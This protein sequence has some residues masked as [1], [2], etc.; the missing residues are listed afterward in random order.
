MNSSGILTQRAT[1][2]WLGPSTLLLSCAVPS[3]EAIV[4]VALVAG[5]RQVPCR[6][7][8]LGSGR[9]LVV[10]EDPPA[11]EQTRIAIDIAGTTHI[12]SAFVA[13]ADFGVP[14]VLRS[15]ASACEN[16]RI[17]ALDFI[18]SQIPLDHG[19]GGSAIM[20]WLVA[21]L[22]EPLPISVGAEDEGAS[23]AL[24]YVGKTSAAEAYVRGWFRSD[25]PP[26]AVRVLCGN[27]SRIELPAAAVWRD[28]PEVDGFFT[29][30][31]KAREFLFLC[32]APSEAEADWLVE[33]TDETGRSVESLPAPVELDPLHVRDRIL[34][35]LAHFK[36]AGADSVLRP[37]LAAVQR[38]I[39]DPGA[40]EAVYR[41]GSQPAATAASVIVPLGDRADL[42]EN[43]LL[44]FCDAPEL[45]TTELLFVLPRSAAGELLETCAG[46]SDLYSAA[47]SV[48]AVDG[49]R[50]FV[51]L[52]NAAVEIAG[53]QILVFLR[54]V[55]MPGGDGWL[56]RAA[57]AGRAG[58]G[59]SAWRV[60]EAETQLAAVAMST[61]HFR[62]AGGLTGD[63][64]DRADLEL[65]SLQMRVARLGVPVR[66]ID[67][68]YDG[69]VLVT[70]AADPPLAGAAEAL[71]ATILRKLVD[72]RVGVE[73]VQICAKSDGVSL[74]SLEAPGA[75]DESSRIRAHDR[76][77]YPARGRHRRIGRGNARR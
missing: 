10:A 25:A 3:N 12:S 29:T 28:R 16:A 5:E 6:W 48:V 56:S 34:N 36:G 52:A 70:S 9:V 59:I 51:S 24:E 21:A 31:G 73:E 47:F 55:L 41:F 76:G 60:D 8:T 7:G 23:V 62:R 49:N 27:G 54:P 26:T 14:S 19:D 33:A 40:V 1:A 39:N 42:L 38:T 45:E 20:R 74:M 68:N 58:V 65:Q 46:L 66:N 50:S 72:Q 18:G 35:D 37:A 71:N 13:D 63:F 30:P 11:L 15:L 2:L 67:S 61:S 22:R 17:D 32:A 64:V 69:P 77:P 44:E 4:D 53:S 43:Q 57:A 75:G